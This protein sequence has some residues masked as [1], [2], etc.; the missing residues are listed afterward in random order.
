MIIRY[1]LDRGL[2][3]YMPTFPKA[4]AFRVFISILPFS[5]ISIDYALT[6]IIKTIQKYM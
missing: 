1:S 5:I 4:S 6:S 2:N 3:R